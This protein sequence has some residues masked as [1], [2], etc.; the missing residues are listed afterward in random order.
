MNERDGYYSAVCNSPRGYKL[1]SE[2][3]CQE[4][5]VPAQFSMESV[6]WVLFF[7]FRYLVYLN[8]NKEQNVICY[9]KVHFMLLVNSLTSASLQDSP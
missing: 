1:P 9:K 6:C 7:Q 4:P 3:K 8:V 2:N 5:T